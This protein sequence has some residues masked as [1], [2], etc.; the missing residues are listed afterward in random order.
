MIAALI[1]YIAFLTLFIVG[2]IHYYENK[3]KEA[4]YQLKQMTKRFHISQRSRLS[5]S[6]GE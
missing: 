6:Q 5:E 3:L 1:T 2:G 4:E